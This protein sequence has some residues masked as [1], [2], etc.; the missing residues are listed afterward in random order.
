MI[1]VV[2]Y[3]HLLG[4]LAILWCLGTLFGGGLAVILCMFSARFNSEEKFDD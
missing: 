2:W 3:E 4:V 1:S